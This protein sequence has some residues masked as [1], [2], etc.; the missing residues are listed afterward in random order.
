[1]ILIYVSTISGKPRLNAAALAAGRETG[2]KQ[3]ERRKRRT[4][5]LR[6][7]R[8]MRR[9]MRRRS[10]GGGVTRGTGGYGN[11]VVC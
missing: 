5:V 1:L 10:T 4:E 9:R 2:G 7:R 6:V 11:V 8:R 3:G